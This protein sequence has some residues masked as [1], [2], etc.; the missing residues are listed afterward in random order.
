MQR[1]SMNRKAELRISPEEAKHLA[2]LLR[3]AVSLNTTAGLLSPDKRRLTT[4]TYRAIELVAGVLE[5]KTF[6]QAID[7]SQKVWSGS[8][9]E[10][11]RLA[12]ELLES[13]RA[14]LKQAMENLLPPERMAEFFEVTEEQFLELL[15]SGDSPRE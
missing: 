4:P 6:E 2:N 11:H 8:L 7:E 10:D 13:T 12:V 5:G 3:Y 14:E 9:E 15:C 1:D